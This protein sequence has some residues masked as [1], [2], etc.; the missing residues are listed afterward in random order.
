L[1]SSTDDALGQF[2]VA[3]PAKGTLLIIGKHG[4][5]L[6]SPENDGGSAELWDY[7]A[8]ELK[9]PFPDSGGCIALSLRGDRLATGN[10]NQT[11]KNLDLPSG[12]FVRSLQTGSD[13]RD[14]FVPRR[15]DPGDEFLGGR[16]ETLGCHQRPADRLAHQHS[17]PSLESGIFA[18]WQVFGNGRRRSNGSPLGRATRQQTEQLQGHGG[19]VMSVAFS[20]DGQTAGQRKQRQEG[21]ALECPSEP[22]VTTNTISS[23]PIFSP[24][25]RFVAAA[26]AGTK[27]PSGRGDASEKAKFDGAH[28]VVAF[29]NR[30]Q[31]SGD[32]GT[33]Y[34]LRF[35]DV[36]TQAHLKTVPGKPAE[37]A[38]FSTPRFR[39][40]A[41]Y[42]WSA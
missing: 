26:L 16:R 31:S 10:T 8:R 25:S 6:F 12:K 30:W 13:C 3:F 19:E 18:R 36:A 20:A 32:R 42:W 14:G 15:L 34:F 4:L 27:W 40:M 24:N 41:K 1:F 38:R 23:A 7:A 28:D 5:P 21:D 35:F 22:A 9:Q 39:R 2:R 17:T 11:I 37:R 33:N 29:F